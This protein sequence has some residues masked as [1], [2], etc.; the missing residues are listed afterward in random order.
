[1][2]DEFAYVYDELMDNVPYHIWADMLHS[3]I[4]KYG[5]SKPCGFEGSADKDLSSE[6][7]KLRSERDLVLDLACGTGTLTELMYQKGYDMI[8]VDI[9]GDMLNAAMEK[10]DRSGSDILYLN[11]D[12]RQLDLFS[13]VGTIYCLCDSINY[14]LSDEDIG[15]VF[16]LCENFL[17][18]GGLFIFDFNTVHKYEDVIGDRT[19]AENREDVSFIWENYYYPDEHINEYD[20]T[21]FTES[22]ERTGYYRKVTETH[23]QKGYLLSEIEGFLENAGLELVTAFELSEDEESEDMFAKSQMLPC[24]DGNQE[25]IFVVSRKKSYH[26]RVVE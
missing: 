14:L 22:P 4:M 16:S 3:L 26:S 9:S 13:T 24:G 17:Y 5:I 12:M 6:Q 11:Q 7:E 2:Y 25:R 19:I 10:R 18:P 15:K 23:L 20:L 1:M 8:G 21:I